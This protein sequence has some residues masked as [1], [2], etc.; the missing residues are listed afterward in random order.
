MLLL[1]FI[2]RISD[3]GGGI[4]HGQV[5]KIFEY[6]YTTSGQ[7]VDER[8]DHGIFGELMQNRAEGPMHGFVTL[9]YCGCAM[10]W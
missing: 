9:L 10:K 8:L 5:K 3:R 2:A 4:S 7:N 6:G 1:Y